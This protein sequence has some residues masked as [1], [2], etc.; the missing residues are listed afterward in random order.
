MKKLNINRTL[1]VAGP[2][3]FLKSLLK[4]YGNTSNSLV[5]KITSSTIP[6]QKL[7][8]FNQ[9]GKIIPQQHMT[10]GRF[11]SNSNEAIDHIYGD[12][13]IWFAPTGDTR[14][15]QSSN[16]GFG[17]NPTPGLGQQTEKFY[18]N[19]IGNTGR[20]GFDEFPLMERSKQ[21]LSDPSYWKNYK[22]LDGKYYD[23]KYNV[24]KER[25]ELDFDSPRME[26][27]RRFNKIM[28][29]KIEGVFNP[30]SKIKII[31]GKPSNLGHS[32]EGN[33][34]DTKIGKY[35][36][37]GYNIIQVIN[38]FTGDQLENILLPNSKH[39]FKVTKID[40]M[41]VDIDNPEFSVGGALARYFK[42]MRLNNKI[43]KYG[44][45]KN[46]FGITANEL[47]NDI[48]TPILKQNSLRDFNNLKNI[49]SQN[50][51]L[52][53]FMED[54]TVDSAPFKSSL[55][56]E[57]YNDG[58]G[59]LMG[60]MKDGMFVKDN[61]Y[62]SK[63]EEYIKSNYITQK[64]V[65]PLALTRNFVMNNGEVEYYNNL[66]KENKEFS[67]KDITSWSTGKYGNNSFG[68]NRLIIKD[69]DFSKPALKNE[70]TNPQKDVVKKERE[71]LM[72]EPKFKVANIIENSPRKGYTG[73]GSEDAN[74]DIE[75]EM[76]KEGG[77]N[78]KYVTSPFNNSKLTLSDPSKL[79]EQIISKYVSTKEFKTGGEQKLSNGFNLK[80]NFDKERNLPFV[81]YNK[82][83]SIEGRVYYNNNSDDFEIINIQQELI[84]KQ[85]KHNRTKEIIVKYEQGKELSPAEKERLNSLG[86]LD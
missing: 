82:Q 11:S 61:T 51:E 12:G 20:Q 75:L 52:T 49:Q 81:S 6:Y 39:K 73:L 7:L 31:D 30:D 8:T 63:L 79:I 48:L 44:K 18:S 9:R 58:K 86:L 38:E 14:Y 84:Q 60:D 28:Q 19:Y 80:N 76:Q 71:V 36:D 13:P 78:K 69:F 32:L 43:K 2:G 72:F 83:P 16:F 4:R 26:P 5:P 25:Y 10:S 35:M 56:K 34:D 15:A 46:S 54:Y 17:Y 33:W 55:K 1:P 57:I 29:N 77:E 42:K 68:Q 41:D 37:E 23:K 67:L 66:F 50:P 22:G 24:S 64:E 70:Y 40:D 47:N 59:I 85:N 21:F 27:S 3:G 53:K 74:Y 62:A 45:S 65:S